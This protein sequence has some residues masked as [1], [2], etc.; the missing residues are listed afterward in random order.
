MFIDCGLAFRTSSPSLSCLGRLALLPARSEQSG[1]IG[2]KI[3][4]LSTWVDQITQHP[5]D[6]SLLS[7][8]GNKDMEASETIETEVVIIGAGS[9]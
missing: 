6:V 4:V 8:P 9:S 3:W 5:E 1:E 7:I 2:W